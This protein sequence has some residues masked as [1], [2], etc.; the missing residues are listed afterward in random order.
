LRRAIPSSSTSQNAHHACGSCAPSGGRN[1]RANKMVS[2]LD[3]PVIPVN[4]GYAMSWRTSARRARCPLHG[5]SSPLDSAPQS[6]GGIDRTA[7][8]ESSA[9]VRPS[10]PRFLFEGLDGLLHS[11]VGITVHVTLLAISKAGDR[12]S[13]RRRRVAARQRSLG[14]CPVALRLR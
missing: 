11:A 12:R 5:N 6:A 3:L 2:A 10:G 1:G 9:E 13:D 8:A 7:I 4:F 14:I